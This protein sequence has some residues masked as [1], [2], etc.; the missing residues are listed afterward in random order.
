MKRKKS[1][2]GFPLRMTALSEDVIAVEDLV[3]Q[4]VKPIRRYAVNPP[5]K[6]SLKVLS[7]SGYRYQPTP[8]IVLQGR[9][10]EVFGFS[11]GSEVDVHCEEDR[12]VIS[13]KP[14]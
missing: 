3:R 8:C 14:R 4:S 7:Q 5:D 11:I 1:N 2:F 12:L 13:R 6:R 9:W 10:L